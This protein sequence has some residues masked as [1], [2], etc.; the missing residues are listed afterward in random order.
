MQI[1]RKITADRVPG[2]DMKSEYLLEQVEVHQHHTE[3]LG[4]GLRP[5][6]D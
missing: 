3:N 5:T 4:K 6:L 2:V 1:K